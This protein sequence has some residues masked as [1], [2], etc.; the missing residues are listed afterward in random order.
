[1]CKGKLRRLR[2]KTSFRKFRL[3]DYMSDALVQSH[4]RTLQE[5]FSNAASAMTAVMVDLRRVSPTPLTREVVAKGFD[6]ESLLYNWLEAVL[7]KKDIDQEIFRSSDVRIRRTSKGLSLR[8]TLHGEP[9]DARRHVFKRD[10]KAITYHEMS[11]TRKDG[12]YTLRFLLD[13]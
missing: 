10:V 6:E 2:T 1:M 9:V 13:L 12:R 8:G 5:G 7:V 11:I 4:G 3:L